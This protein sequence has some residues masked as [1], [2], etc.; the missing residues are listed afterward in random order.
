MCVVPDWHAKRLAN[1]LQKGREEVDILREYGRI[2]HTQEAC[3]AELSAFNIKMQFPAALGL[4]C[5]RPIDCFGAFA[6][7]WDWNYRAL[8][9]RVR[10]KTVDGVDDFLL[11]SC[12][13]ITLVPSSFLHPPLGRV[14]IRYIPSHVFGCIVLERTAWKEFCFHHHSF[15]SH[16]LNHSNYGMRKERTKKSN[17]HTAMCKSIELRCYN[18]A[19][20]AM[21]VANELP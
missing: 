3:A 10:A 2:L 18:N 9:M 8:R 1:F 6:V 14:F 16:V 17:N 7:E 19:R 15:W 12:T 11:H 20:K 4:P 5:I 13:V 21:N